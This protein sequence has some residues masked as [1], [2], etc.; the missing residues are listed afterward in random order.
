MFGGGGECVQKYEN[1]NG[2]T[3][4]NGIIIKTGTSLWHTIS[5][6]GIFVQCKIFGMFICFLIIH[7][8]QKPK[9][10]LVS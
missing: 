6:A 5:Y 1:L 2:I 9:L 10:L 8:P 3:G 7:W 4:I